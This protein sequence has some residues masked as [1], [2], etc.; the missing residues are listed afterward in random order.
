MS[1]YYICDVCY[2]QHKCVDALVRDVLVDRYEYLPGLV[3][4]PVVVPSLVDGGELVCEA[5]MLA[6]E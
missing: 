1:R 6:E 2:K 3:K 5:V 4:Q